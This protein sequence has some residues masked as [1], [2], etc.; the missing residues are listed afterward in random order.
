[1]Q[2]VRLQ[3]FITKKCRKKKHHVKV[4]K[5]TVDL[6][7]ASQII[8]VFDLFKVSKITTFVQSQKNNYYVFDLFKVSKITIDL[9][10]VRKM[11]KMK[12]FFLTCLRLALLL[13]INKKKI[14]IIII[15][16]YYKKNYYK[17]LY[18]F[19]F[20]TYIQKW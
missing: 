3:I 11:H 6:I 9:F 5:I 8:I 10:K 12:Y 14:I 7:K 15:Y 1:M 20:F 17:K 16:Y 13:Y 4:S 19:V 18:F 2:S